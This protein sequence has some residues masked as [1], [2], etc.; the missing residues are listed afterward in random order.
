MNISLIPKELEAYITSLET[1]NAQMAEDMDKMASVIESLE[2]KLENA[3]ITIN[4]LLVEVNNG[5]V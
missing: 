5:S 3:H 2:D 1:E 4:R